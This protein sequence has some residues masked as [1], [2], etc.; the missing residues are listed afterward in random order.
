[1]EKVEFV[2]VKPNEQNI[3]EDLSLDMDQTDLVDSVEII[4]TIEPK[5]TLPSSSSGKL[6][7]IQNGYIINLAAFSSVERANRFIKMYGLDNT[8]FF[9]RAK[10]Y[11]QVVHGTF[12]T[13]EDAYEALERLPLEIKENSPVVKSMESKYRIYGKDFLSLII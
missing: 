2:E 12:E 7:Y 3:S 13:K 1:M 5:P 10:N 6:K 9:H 11:I 4:Q 8:T